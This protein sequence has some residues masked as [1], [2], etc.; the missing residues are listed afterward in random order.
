ML[1]IIY[2]SN[3]KK[4]LRFDIK[5]NSL[6][7]FINLDNV[8]RIYNELLKIKEIKEIKV[9]EI[10]E[11][12]RKLCEKEYI[13]IIADLG[14]NYKSVNWWANPVSEKNEHVLDHYKNLCLFY[15]LIKTLRKYSEKDM[16]VFV[17]C[18]DEIYNQLK[19]YC[20]QNNIKLL[21]LEKYIFLQL[22]TIY[23]NC[24]NLLRIAFSLMKVIMRKVYVS[25]KMTYGLEGNDYKT[26]KYY[27]I[28]T[29]LDNRFILSNKDYRDAYFGKLHEYASRN[30][31]KVV[32]LVG[33]VRNFREIVQKIRWTKD[34]LFIPEEILLRYTDLFRLFSYMF[35]KKIKLNQ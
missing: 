32:F 31:F 17:I 15:S 8:S 19:I 21:S 34:I 3:V 1:E 23:T 20:N 24:Y 13:N 10:N 5:K 6:Y 12:D 28:R 18:N 2:S 27:V 26:K 7:S 16:S 35:I 11:E 22:R 30:G 14:F 33:I 9:E 29:W 4:I 25:Y